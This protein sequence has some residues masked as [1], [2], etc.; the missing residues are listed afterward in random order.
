MLMLTDPLLPVPGAGL[1]ALVNVSTWLDSTLGGDVA[2]LLITHPPARRHGDSADSIELRMRG[3]GSALGL[4][5]P[6]APL[7]DIGECLRL[8]RG[9]TALLSIGGCRYLLRA[10]VGV[11][12]WS[13]FVG[14][15][16]P[17][18]VAVMFD[19]VPRGTDRAVLDSLITAAAEA[20]RMV[21]GKTYVRDLAAPRIRKGHGGAG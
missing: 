13:E 10:P 3:L 1:L 4:A 11:G 9:T 14:A 2:F 7:P 8:H 18:A 5:P 17:V 19:A 6:S 12:R 20:D 21:L 15:G 16:G